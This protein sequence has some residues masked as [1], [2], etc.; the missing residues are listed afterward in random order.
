V[1]KATSSAESELLSVFP[2]ACSQIKEENLLALKHLLKRWTQPAAP[3][4]A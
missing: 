4:Q 1:V 2:D 3:Q